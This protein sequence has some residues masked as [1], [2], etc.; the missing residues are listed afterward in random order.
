MLLTTQE[1]SQRLDR[2]IPSRTRRPLVPDSCGSCGHIPADCADEC[3]YEQAATPAQPTVTDG[4]VL[5]DWAA[6]QARLRQIAVCRT[7]HIR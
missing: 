7:H 4:F 5:V 1:V 6:Y 2:L 3:C